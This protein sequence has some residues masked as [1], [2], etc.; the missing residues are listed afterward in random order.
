MKQ[1]DF[2]YRPPSA[3]RSLL[4]NSDSEDEEQEEEIEAEGI[5]RLRYLV[6]E[7]IRGLHFFGMTK[8]TMEDLA[9]GWPAFYS[10]LKKNHGDMMNGCTVVLKKRDKISRS[11]P[12]VML[13]DHGMTVAFWDEANKSASYSQSEDLARALERFKRTVD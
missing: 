11:T 2:A 5:L 6:R 9:T 8:G 10:F 12:Y 4:R 1:Q 3:G 7:H 13:P